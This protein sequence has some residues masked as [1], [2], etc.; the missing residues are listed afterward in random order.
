MTGDLRFLSHRDMVRHL[1]RAA[2]RAGW[3]VRYAGRFNPHPRISLPVPRPVGV[4]STAEWAVVE[5]DAAADA[6]GL[7]AS[8][9]PQCPA[10]LR[11]DRV[12]PVPPGRRLVPARCRYRLAVA[13]AATRRRVAGRITALRSAATFP[14]RRAPRPTKPAAATVER[15]ID[16]RPLVGEI[17][18]GADGLELDLAA[19]PGAAA[20]PADVLH[21]L[22]LPPAA[23]LHRL[24]RTQTVWMEDP[25]KE[26]M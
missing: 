16:L 13:D 23:Y 20:R 26:S 8:L 5:L 9:A 15:T 14:I 7:F 1:S 11:V 25:G 24:R 2:A 4:A 3:P 6:D 22:D 18:L 17:A 10:G 19:A 12:E 21:A